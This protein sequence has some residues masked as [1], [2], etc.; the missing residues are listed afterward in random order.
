M[1]IYH[2]MWIGDVTKWTS[3]PSIAGLQEDCNLAVSGLGP[4]RGAA[5]S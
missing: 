4:R 1:W 5:L 3:R 2:A